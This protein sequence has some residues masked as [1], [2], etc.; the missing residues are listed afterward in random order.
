MTRLEKS[1]IIAHLAN[2]FKTHDYFYII[3]PS[4]L[5]AEEAN[6]FRRK[7]DQSGIVYQVAKNTLIAKALL[8]TMGEEKAATYTPLTDT[9]LKGPS[10]IL[11]GKEAGSLPAKVLQAFKKQTK[12]PKPVL[13]AA[14]VDDALFIGPTHL[15]ALSKLKS[16]AELMADIVAM[17]QSP[18]TRVI[19]ALQSGQHQLAG[20]VKT[21]TDPAAEKH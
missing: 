21:L 10:G 6:S 4:G 9:A 15:E 2:H 14:S 18:M 7:C 12:L 13:K 19:T 3:D 20:I 11:F 16:K 8:A 17:L 1:K 5:S